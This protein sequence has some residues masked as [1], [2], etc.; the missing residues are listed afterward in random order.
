MAGSN[1]VASRGPLQRRDTR[2]AGSRMPR[3]LSLLHSAPLNS[4]VVPVMGSD[5]REQ[6]AGEFA[7]AGLP[8]DHRIAPMESS[9]EEFKAAQVQEALCRV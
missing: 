5:D 4:F 7:T 3:R 6:V 2:N 9:L 8:A 1:R